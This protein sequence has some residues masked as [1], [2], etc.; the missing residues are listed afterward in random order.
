MNWKSSMKFTGYLLF[1]VGVSDWKNLFQKDIGM[2]LAMVS[3]E[4]DSD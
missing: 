2:D 3:N 1:R 4:V